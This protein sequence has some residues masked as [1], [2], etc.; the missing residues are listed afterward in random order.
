MPKHGQCT[1]EETH[2]AVDALAADGQRRVCERWQ[3]LPGWQRAQGDAALARLRAR[4]LRLREDR[5]DANAGADG[6]RR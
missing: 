3:P 5:V 2:R 6:A 1:V 4:V